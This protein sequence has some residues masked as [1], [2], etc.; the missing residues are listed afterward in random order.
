[1]LGRRDVAVA[2]ERRT[3]T[4][5]SGDTAALATAVDPR[6]SDALVVRD[7][8]GLRKLLLGVVDGDEGLRGL[9]E[10]QF[11]LS[12]ARLSADK[13]LRS[14]VIWPPVVHRCHAASCGRDDFREICGGKT[15]RNL[16]RFH[17]GY[18]RPD[19]GYGMNSSQF[20]TSWLELQTN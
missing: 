3:V 13:L 7:T 1:M 11:D 5:L 19:D 20:I 15:M 2:V 6:C 10:E 18:G 8:P 16:C 9:I 17:D 12:L 14:Y 4:K